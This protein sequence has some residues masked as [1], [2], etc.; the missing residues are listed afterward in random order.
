MIY[1]QIAICAF[2]LAFVT[3]DTP[4]IFLKI[5]R[6]IVT[7]SVGQY[8]NVFRVDIGEAQREVIRKA[9]DRLQK[10]PP[11]SLEDVAV[12]LRLDTADFGPGMVKVEAIYRTREEVLDAYQDYVNELNAESDFESEDEKWAVFGGGFFPEENGYEMGDLFK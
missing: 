8:E 4:G 6:E 10:L 12:D 2:D 11:D 9:L 5:F 7:E 3:A 1:A